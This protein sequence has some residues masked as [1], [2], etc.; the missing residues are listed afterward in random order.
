MGLSK[1]AGQNGD[2]RHNELCEIFLYKLLT[3]ALRFSSL[4]SMHVLKSLDFLDGRC[5]LACCRAAAR[6]VDEDIQ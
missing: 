5:G 4:A 3:F 1:E 6:W 2:G